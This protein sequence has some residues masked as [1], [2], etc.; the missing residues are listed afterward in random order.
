MRA[1]RIFLTAATVFALAAIG[2]AAE[3]AFHFAL[4]RSAPAADATVPAPVEVRL[5]FT[6]PP[7]AGSVGIRLV[8]Q[9]GEAVATNAAAADPELATSYLVKPSATLQAGPYTVSWRGIGD[10]G[11]AVTGTFV[12]TVAAQ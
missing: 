4:S 6:E 1:H 8:N 12:F 10:D 11:H 5:W 2:V 3:S 9:A 7:E